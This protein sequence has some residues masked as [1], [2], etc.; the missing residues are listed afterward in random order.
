[1]EEC[2]LGLHGKYIKAVDIPFDYEELQNLDRIENYSK[3]C[4]L[5]YL[6]EYNVYVLI[7]N[8]FTKF[9]SNKDRFQSWK[10]V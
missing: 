1:M 5:Q 9:V 2:Y 6:K 8:D 7:T 3:T 10:K 4:E